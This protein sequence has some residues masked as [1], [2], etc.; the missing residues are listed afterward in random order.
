M[1][2]TTDESAKVIEALNLGLRI[3]T[4]VRLAGLPRGVGDTVLGAI[5]T[6]ERAM[7]EAMP[8]LQAAKDRPRPA[9]DKP[10]RVEKSSGA[11]VIIGPDGRWPFHFNNEAIAKIRAEDFN[12]VY[13][14][15]CINNTI[16]TNEHL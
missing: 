1:N 2:L 7:D 14:S 5:H 13:A 9:V 6:Y 15:A 10:Y 16:A 11:Y 8:I 3:A 4:E 12:K